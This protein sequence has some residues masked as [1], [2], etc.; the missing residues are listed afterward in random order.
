MCQDFHRQQVFMALFLNVCALP[1]SIG[2]ED[3]RKRAG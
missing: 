2:I 1:G 3:D